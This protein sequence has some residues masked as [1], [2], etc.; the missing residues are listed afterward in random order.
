[1]NVREKPEPSD[2]AEPRLGIAV[3]E[4]VPEIRQEL[5]LPPDTKG[6]VIADVQEGS[7]A[8][9]A[10]LLPGDVIQEVDRKPIQNVSQFQAQLAARG[11]DPLL[12]RVNRG[13]RTLFVAIK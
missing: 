5:E 7:A 10:G 3:T 11:K 8:A 12:M 4:L 2:S 13:G 6:I 9:E 1:L